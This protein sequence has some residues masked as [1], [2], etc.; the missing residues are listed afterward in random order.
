MAGL[1]RK[2]VGIVKSD[3]SGFTHV[4]FSTA[5]LNA[6][7]AGQEPEDFTPGVRSRNLPPYAGGDT[8]V[9]QSTHPYQDGGF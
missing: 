7:R 5:A 1:S 8:H 6:L 3:G 2:K 9:E 4:D